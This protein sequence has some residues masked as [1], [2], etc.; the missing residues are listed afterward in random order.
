MDVGVQ[1]DRPKRNEC[2]M[3]YDPH[4]QHVDPMYGGKEAKNFLHVG[5]TT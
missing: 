1:I 2:A 4:V 5:R 3:M